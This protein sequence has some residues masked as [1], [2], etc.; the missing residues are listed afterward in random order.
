MRAHSYL[1]DLVNSSLHLPSSTTAF[2]FKPSENVVPA[3]INERNGQSAVMVVGEPAWHRLGSVLDCPATAA[4]AMAAAK[5]DW[6]VAKQPLLTCNSD[7]E[8]VKEIYDRYAV[9]RQDD[10]NDG[11]ATVLGIVGRDYTPLQNSDS[12][13]FFDPI[14]GQGA[15]VYHSAGALGDGERVWILAKLPGNIRVIG[16]DITEKYLLL[17]NSHD[18]NSAVQ[19]KF[20]PIRVVCENTLTMA[21]RDGPT[22]RLAHT[23]DVRERMRIA[24]NLLNAITVRYDQ[25]QSVF[26]AMVNT[27]MDDAREGKYFREVFPD[28]RRGGDADRYER[29]LAQ[30]E[31]D[32]AE[33]KQRAE[34]GKGTDLAG[35]RGTLWAAYNGITEYIDYGRYR[36]AIPNRQLQAIWFGD[37]YSA[38]ARA[39]KAAEHNLKAWAN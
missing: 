24:A 39:F 32:R 10:W 14:V 7:Y 29:A 11:K 3:N 1:Y 21:L 33:S 12:F 13:N 17:S 36:S 9:V 38:K 31:K 4:Q 20:T 8:Q 27:K 18:G 15:A 26:G 28:P 5:L 22:L 35:V 37:G 34:A 2:K 6:K 25:I 23:R 16:D 30:A 19:I